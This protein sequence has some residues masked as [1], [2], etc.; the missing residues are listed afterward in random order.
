MPPFP[1]PGS[2]IQ[3]FTLALLCRYLHR[4]YYEQPD[5]PELQLPH[6]PSKTMLLVI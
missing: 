3:A 2:D 6:P 1:F 4:P 5:E